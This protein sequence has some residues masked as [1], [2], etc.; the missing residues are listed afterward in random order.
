M[1]T[2][3]VDFYYFYIVCVDFKAWTCFYDGKSDKNCA[4][5]VFKDCKKNKQKTGSNLRAMLL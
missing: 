4:E 2:F 1:F 3:S 5:K